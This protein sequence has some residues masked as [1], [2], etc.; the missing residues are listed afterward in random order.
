V[1]VVS[2][3]WLLSYHHRAGFLSLSPQL[4][5]GGLELRLDHSCVRWLGDPPLVGRLLSAPSSGTGRSALSIPRV[6]SWA[7]S[8][9]LLSSSA[10]L[11]P[12][13]FLLDLA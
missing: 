6:R 9:E 4:H 10:L 12:P 13:S 2:I 1:V 8:S 3:T 11:L 5:V 7:L